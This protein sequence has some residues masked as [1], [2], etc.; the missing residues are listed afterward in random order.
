MVKSLYKEKLR[1]RL[2]G[3]K[4][5][6]YMLSPTSDGHIRSCK[7]CE[8]VQAYKRPLDIAFAPLKWM[9]L[10]Q[11]NEKNAKKNMEKLGIPT[12]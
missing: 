2:F 10:V 6:Y 1:C 4:W 7:N 8:M 3:H 12:N 9:I 5:R 11:Y